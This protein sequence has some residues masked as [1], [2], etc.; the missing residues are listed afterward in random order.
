MGPLLISVPD[1]PSGLA[2][3]AVCL[4]NTAPGREEALGAH[5]TMGSV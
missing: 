5:K 3:L 2:W 4:P 1:L